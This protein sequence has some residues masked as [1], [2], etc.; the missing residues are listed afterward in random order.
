MGNA[1][2][3]ATSGAEGLAKLHEM[4]GATVVV[5][6]MRMPVMDGAAFLTQ[7]RKHWPDA[8]PAAPY[9]RDRPGRR[10]GPLSTRGKFLDF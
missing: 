8:T 9:R 4:N 10:G 2:M 1:V 6:D 3:T 5:S 7:V